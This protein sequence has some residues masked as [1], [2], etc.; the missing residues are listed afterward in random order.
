MYLYIYIILIKLNQIAQPTQQTC[1]CLLRFNNSLWTA[2]G[3]LT[4]LNSH[5]R[6]RRFSVFAWRQKQEIMKTG[7]TGIL[8][9]ILSLF[10]KWHWFD[11]GFVCCTYSVLHYIISSLATHTK[12]SST[13]YINKPLIE[14]V[15]LRSWN[16]EIWVS[17]LAKPRLPSSLPV[18]RNSRLFNLKVSCWISFFS[19]LNQSSPS[20]LAL[21]MSPWKITN[22]KGRLSPCRSGS[23]PSKG[24]LRLPKK[25]RRQPWKRQKW[26]PTCT[27]SHSK[28]QKT[29]PNS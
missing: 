7:N 2:W 18:M 23:P 19:S 3:D 24:Y 20:W 13:A 15:T 14:C 17:F 28:W 8:K 1:W 26:R 27:R 12:T 11:V 29:L 21:C 6:P 4:T 10:E 16:L 5:R 22:K 9:K 25:L